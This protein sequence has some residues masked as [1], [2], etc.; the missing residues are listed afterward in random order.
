MSSVI[1]TPLLRKKKRRRMT[2]LITPAP[3]LIVMEQQ[4]K[5]F[6]TFMADN[7]Q[8]T[9]RD[10]MALQLLTDKVAKMVVSRVNHQSQQSI[11]SCF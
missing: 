9:A 2:V 10:E 7:P 1:A 6:A 3:S 5:G 4:L 8:F 11:R